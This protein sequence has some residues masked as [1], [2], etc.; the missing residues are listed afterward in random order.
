MNRTVQLADVPKEEVDQVVADFNT[1]GAEV[2]TIRQ[3]N[4][5]WTVKAV[6][7]ES[8]LAHYST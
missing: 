1:A 7:P 4:G 3:P 6:I 5:K 2:Q 8:A